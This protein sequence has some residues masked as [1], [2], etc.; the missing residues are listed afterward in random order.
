M[1]TDTCGYCMAEM[2]FQCD[3]TDDKSPD[4]CCCAGTYGRLSLGMFTGFAPT[5]GDSTDSSELSAE[6]TNRSD[7]DDTEHRGPGRPRINSG[8]D[9]KNPLKAGRRRA[10]NLMTIPPG[11]VCEWALL[12]YAGGGIEPI[13]GCAGNTAADK[14]HGPDKGTLNNEPGI[15]LHRICE[16]CHNRWHELND[17]YYSD[18]PVENVGYL[19]LQQYGECHDHDRLTRADSRVIFAS[20][21]WWSQS[22]SDRPAYR[23]WVI[24]DRVA[25]ATTTG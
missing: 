23:E 8:A 5:G 20:D 21:K 15:N 24:R 9:M 2:C 10:E 1:S 22:K 11:Y 18:R 17:K 7:S 14:H 19:P 3:S 6:S 16:H 4:K 13:V 12:E 25:R